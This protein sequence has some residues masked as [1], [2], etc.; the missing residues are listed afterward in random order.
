[1]YLTDNKDK[2]NAILVE[3]CRDS[4][5]KKQAW[6]RYSNDESLE[7]LTGL[8]KT[9]GYDVLEKIFVKSN[10]INP[11]SFLG[12][13]KVDEFKDL[14]KQCQADWVVFN[15]D[16]TPSQNRNIENSLKCNVID[17]CALIIE[18]FAK[19]ARTRESKTQVELAR[20][21]YML[22]RLTGRW[23]HLSRQRGGIGLRE[24]GEKQLEIDR[25]L[26]QKRIFKLKKELESIDRE[27][28]IQRKNRS[29][30]FKAALVGYTNAGKST[31]MNSLTGS[32]LLVENKLFA[33]LDSTVR[34]LKTAGR[35]KILIT[36]TV[37][38]IDKLPHSLV[39][40]FKST[41]D[42]IR[43]TNLIIKVVDITHQ[44]FD[45]HISTTQKVLQELGVSDI[46]SFWV[47][48]KIDLIEE[49]E[50]LANL[51]SRHPDSIFVSGKN[52]S[53]INLLKEKIK[54]SMAPIS[55]FL[56]A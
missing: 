13:G 6:D 29:N 51:K 41:L 24:V 2:R 23:S 53:G 43:Y 40:S 1:M 55:H 11:R 37:G 46:P 52:S 19:H 32:S 38:L 35:P 5:L 56:S 30:L 50:I 22:P 25:R 10:K 44:C 9:A 48:N 21:N 16:L 17:R 8:A 45:K 14:V 39:A 12:K 34:T 15:E 42:E 33:T 49:D 18:I 20:L 31:L 27:R 7:E 36:D 28:K 3:L 54:S 47:F 4:S 26:I